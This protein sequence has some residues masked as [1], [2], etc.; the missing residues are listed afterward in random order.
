MADANHIRP[1]TMHPYEI[2]GVN[3]DEW[4]DRFRQC[5]FANEEAGL[6]VLGFLADHWHFYQRQ[7]LTEDQIIQ[8]QC[9]VDLLICLGVWEPDLARRRLLTLLV[10]EEEPQTVRQRLHG[11]LR[12]LR[13]MRTKRNDMPLQ[14]KDF[15]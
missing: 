8:R 2:R 12:G 3:A 10:Q 13:Q 9:F 5:F 4:I 11:W 1:V 14:G 15:A 7:L 6:A